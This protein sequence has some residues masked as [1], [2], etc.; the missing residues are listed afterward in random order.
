MHIAAA[1]NRPEGVTCSEG[2]MRLRILS[3]YSRAAIEHTKAG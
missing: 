3:G 1:F 2:D